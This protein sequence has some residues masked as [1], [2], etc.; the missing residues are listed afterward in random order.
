MTVNWK[1]KKINNIIKGNKAQY[2]RQTAKISAL[3]SGNA[4]KYEF[5]TSQD[6]LPE[7]ELLDDPNHSFYKYHDIEMMKKIFYY[8]HHHITI[9][10][11]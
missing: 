4:D 5:L 9:K 7:T 3:S 6:V 8:I 11:S 2:D 10:R 1:S